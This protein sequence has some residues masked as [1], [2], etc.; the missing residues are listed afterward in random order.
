MTLRHGVALR[1]TRFTARAVILGGCVLLCLLLALAIA[2]CALAAGN[3]WSDVSRALLDSYDVREA[4]LA[5]LDPGFADGTWRPDEVVSR[6]E[7]A[8]F[9]VIGFGV[10]LA[11]PAEKHFS[12][13]FPGDEYYQ[14]VEGAYA[15]GFVNGLLDGSFNVAGTILRQQAVALIARWL[16]AER[17]WDIPTAYTEGQIEEILAPF[18]DAYLV[19]PGLRCQMAFAVDHGI[20]WGDAENLLR[21][22]EEITRIELASLIAHALEMPASLTPGA[23]WI[24]MTSEIWRFYDL[25]ARDLREFS[26]GY[27]DRTWRPYQP[28]DRKQAVSAAVLAFGIAPAFPTTPTFT[29]VFPGDFFYQYIEGAAAVHL[30]SGLLDGS[31]H[32]NDGMT[33]LQAALFIAKWMATTKGYNL[34]QRYPTED[35][36]AAVLAV[37]PD[38]VDDPALIQAQARPLLAFA[39][40]FGIMRPDEGGSLSPSATL[41]RIEL[42]SALVHA[43]D[44]P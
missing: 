31:F 16:E 15:A 13:V 6:G 30:V 17:G 4:D 5:A 18:A 11:N 25:S 8:K 22:R 36:V 1:R 14:Y 39:T 9:F 33:R 20:I 3:T 2:P 27:P 41:T 43:L 21:P 42:A 10:P 12:D 28:V 7:A 26:Q 32:P 34:A 29:D 35:D 24:D 19:S 44:V 38:L 23:N 40:Q 37:Y